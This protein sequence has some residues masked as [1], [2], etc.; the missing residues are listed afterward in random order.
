M[1]SLYSIK[2]IGV[3]CSV[4]ALVITMSACSSDTSEVTETSS[5]A[6]VLATDEYLEVI[7]HPEDGLL[8]FVVGP[9]DMAADAGHLRLPIQK[10]EIPFDLFGYGFEWDIRNS[11]GEKLPN[12][13]LHHMNLI[14]IDSRE[15]FSPVARRVIAAGR[16]TSSIEFPKIVGIPVDAGHRLWIVSM[17]GNPTGKDYSDAYLHVNLKYTRPED[18]ILPTMEVYTFYMDATGFVGPKD[19]PVP[20]GRSEKSYT[21]RPGVDGT[22]LGIGGH[23]HDYATEIRLEDATAGEV[24]WEGTPIVNEDGRTTGVSKDLLLAELGRKIYADHDYKIVVVHE[25]PTDEY[26]SDGGMGAIGGIMTVTGDGEWPELDANHP[27]YVEDLENT[28]LEPTRMSAHG[29]GGHAGMDMEGAAPAEE[30]GGHEHEAETPD[31]HDH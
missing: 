27:D 22:I 26:A 1:N 18:G 16:E 12:D 25:N 31:D 3:I 20:P 29:H 4:I 21:A 15:L 24:V 23:M 11:A 19:F 10:T 17:F 6:E 9:F 13:L 2:N 28:L 14:D 8:E 5:V 7:D 30:S